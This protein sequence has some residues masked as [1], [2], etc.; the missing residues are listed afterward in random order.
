M[1]KSF[2]L[3][4]IAVVFKINEKLKK[5]KKKEIVDLRGLLLS[6]LTCAS[7]YVEIVENLSNIH[8]LNFKYRPL[9]RL[10]WE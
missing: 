8:M 5:K 10:K 6:T 9:I 2:V 1:S 7:I 3:K 4:Y